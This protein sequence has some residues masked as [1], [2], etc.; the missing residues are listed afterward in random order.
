ML[1]SEQAGTCVLGGDMALFRGDRGMLSQALR[2]GAL[3]YHPGRLRGA[4]PHVAP[5]A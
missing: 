1:P 2:D 4:W 5:H 3:S